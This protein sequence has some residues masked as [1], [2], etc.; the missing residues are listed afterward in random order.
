M[1]AYIVALDSGTHADATAAQSAITGAGAT[2]TETYS[3]NLTYKIDCTAEQLAAIAGVLHS[4][5]ETATEDVTVQYS[6]DHLKHLCNNVDRSLASAYRPR[7][8]GTGST[9]YLLDTGI[10]ESHDEFT[11]SSITN[12]Y[13]AFGTDYSDSTGHGTAMASLING[14]NIGVSPNA[15]LFNIKF[16]NSVSSSISIG[17]IIEAMNAALVHHKANTPNKVKTLCMPW[18]TAKNSLVDAKLQELETHNMM[19]I[20]SAGNN[21]AD[22]DNYS[23]AGLDQVM[24]VGSYNDS[25]QVGAFGANGTWAGGSAGT[26]LGEEVDIYALGSN[27][28][29]ASHSDNTSY[30][31]AYGT[32]PST[33][34]IAG[35]S[36]QYIQK[37][38]TATSTQIK[39]FIVGEGSIPKRGAN[40]T[41]D[42]GLISSTGANVELLSK[43]IGVSPQVNDVDLASIPSGVVIIVEQGQTG[44]VDIGLNSGASNVSV[45][46]FSPLPPFATFNTGTGVVSVDTTSNMDG[47]TVPGKYHFAIRGDVDSVTRVEEY[48]IGVIATGGQETSLD[49]A[50]EYYYDGT[51]FDQVV[52]FAF[53]K[54]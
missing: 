21:A 34:I 19:V 12:L 43:S 16:S 37:E 38:P 53:W 14:D 27:V 30:G 44:T 47:V 11:N 41:F 15:S 18:T 32:S 52:N 51:N 23:P 46:G 42:S 48:T 25:Y 7:H 39:S 1:A 49:T 10:N 50:P 28:S 4:S 26:N 31:T 2:I 3:F 54:E 6:T 45:L 17:T 9:I 40:I 8:D 22:V 20:C 13:T 29:I 24:T 36:A 35:L 5:L 33:A